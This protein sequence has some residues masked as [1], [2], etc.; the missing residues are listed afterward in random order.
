MERDSLDN[1]INRAVREALIQERGGLAADI[2]NDSRAA[3]VGL[4]LQGASSGAGHFVAATFPQLVTALMPHMSAFLVST[5][6]AGYPVKQ[7]LDY[8]GWKIK[9]RI[10]Q[11]DGKPG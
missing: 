6:R 3:A 7:A 1:L 5:H 8:I 4:V 10:T 2:A 9:L 11:S